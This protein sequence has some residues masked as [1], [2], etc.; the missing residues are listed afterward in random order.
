M[1]NCNYSISGNYY[2]TEKFTD[3]NKDQGWC[4][5][6]CKYKNTN[7]AYKCP[8]CTDPDTLKN[9]PESCQKYD[10]QKNCPKLAKTGNCSDNDVLKKCP[11]SCQK[12]DQQQNCIKKAEEGYCSDQN[13]LKNCKNACAYFDKAP[14]CATKAAQG[15]CTAKITENECPVSCK[16]QDSS[17]YCNLNLNNADEAECNNPINLKTCNMTCTK[18]K[19]ECNA[20]ANAGKCSDPNISNKCSI[21]CKDKNKLDDCDLRR[22]S[23]HCTLNADYMLLNCPESC[24]KDLIANCSNLINKNCDNPNWAQNYIDYTNTDHRNY[25]L[26]RDCPKSCPK[27]I[28]LNNDINNIC[29]NKVK[30]RENACLRNDT[31]SIWL[32]NNCPESCLYMSNLTKEKE[33]ME[34]HCYWEATESSCKNIWNKNVINKCPITCAKILQK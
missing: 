21:A 15:R 13:V 33:S 30:E 19:E 23:G 25:A 28:P 7:Y 12:Y 5:N 16:T 29:W 27:I 34:T 1:S 24:S 8:K 3:L 11:E 17:S 14:D 9:C 10:Q 32:K 6:N 18:K 31:E 20:W 22:N 26:R 2:C 4:P